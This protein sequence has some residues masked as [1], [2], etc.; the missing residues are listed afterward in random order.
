MLAVLKS[1]YNTFETTKISKLMSMLRQFND[2][3]KDAQ[4]RCVSR[5]FVNGT[6]VRDCVLCYCRTQMRLPTRS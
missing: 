6:E 2:K 4:V 5:A 1:R 3:M